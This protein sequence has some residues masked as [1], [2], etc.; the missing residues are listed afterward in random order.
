MSHLSFLARS[1]LFFS[2]A[3][4]VFGICS[5]E[6]FGS[7]KEAKKKEMTFLEFSL[8]PASDKKPDSIVVLLHGG[9]DTGENFLFLA[10]LLGQFLPNTLFVAPEGPIASKSISGG[11]L[12]YSAS[13]NNKAQQLKEINALTPFLNQYL[14]S[15]LKK[16]NIPPEKLALFGFSQGARIALHI[17]LRRPPCAGIVAFSGSYLNDPKAKNLSRPPILIIHGTKDQKAPVSFAQES[18][19]QLDALKMP[20]TLI[21]LKGIEHDIDPQGLGIAGEFLRDCLYEENSTTSSQLH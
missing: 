6:A 16:Y 20:V 9:G 1:L 10:A 7:A 8:P 13:K 2:F 12:W 5:L 11:R 19:K 14:D 15:L 3:A 17:G 4:M 21:L 18:F